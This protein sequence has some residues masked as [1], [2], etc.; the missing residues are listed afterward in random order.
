MN[1]APKTRSSR[2]WL[3][4]T[5]ALMVLAWA[6]LGFLV[7]PRLLRT[8]AIDTVRERLHREL[9]LG[10]IGFNPF[11]FELTVQDASLP[12][13][14]GGPAL[15]FQRLVL[16]AEPWRSLWHR[17][18][19]LA[20]LQVDGLTAAAVIRRDGTLNLADLA[21][22]A[23]PDDGE[24]RPLRLQI[25]RLAVTSG[26]LAFRELD[27]P[28]PFET[29]LQPI[30]FE[31]Q[32][33]STLDTQGNAYHFTAR[34]D[35]G[36][37]LDWSGKVFLQPFRSHGDFRIG[38]LRATT[39]ANY[40]GE[41]LPFTVTSGALD[42][43]G[44]Y[45][46]A[47]SDGPL[48]LT[49]SLDQLDIKSLGLRTRA[50]TQDTLVLDSLQVQGAQANLTR[51]EARVEHVVLTGG[52]INAWL[53]AA[54]RL[55]LQDLLGTEQLAKP[56]SAP[57]AVPASAAPWHYDVP[58]IRVT[59][60]VLN[61]EDQGLDPHPRLQLTDI[62]LG[63]QGYSSDDT[64]PVEV[65]L[66]LQ[67]NHSGQLQAAGQI[68]PRDLS[69]QG[70]L[71]LTDIDLTALQPY[72]QRDTDLTL[73]GG[74]LGA[75]LAL[76]RTATG[77]LTAQGDAQVS[78][79]RSIDNLLRQDFVKW[80]RLQARGI[81]YRSDP[82]RL[83]VRELL[84]RA[85]YARVV[86]GGDRILNLTHILNPPGKAKIQVQTEGQ[87]AVA[88]LGPPPDI[89]I[90]V[91]RIEKAAANFADFWIKPNF[92]VGLLD[93]DGTI[94][95]LSAKSGSRAQVDLH[96]MVDRYAPA[97]IRGEINPL[98]ASAYSDLSMTFRNMDMTTV[99]PYSG[100]FAGYQIRKGKLS[101]E[102]SYKIQD[103]KL[104]AGHHVVIDQLELGERV[105]SPDAT[106]LPVR[107]AVA[108]LK[109]RH[110][111][112]DVQL[113]VTGSLDD[114][115]F[116]LS[117]LVWKAI[118]NL[119]SKA[120]TAPFALL[121]GLFG[122]SD[123]Q[124]NQIAFAPGSSTPD[125]ASQARLETLR[126][127]LVER[128]GLE[129]EVPAA[130][131]PEQDRPALLR[132]QLAVRL[133]G[134]AAKAGADPLA[135][136]AAVFR[137]DAGPTAPLPTEGTVE[138]LETAVLARLVVSDAELAELGKARAAAVQD[139]LFSQGGLDPAR[140]FVTNGAPASADAQQLRID[141]TLK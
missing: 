55:N 141:L 128:P 61:A 108:L 72:L 48:Q 81:D 54:G 101:V 23:G 120:A 14:D 113:P 122:G 71:S 35:A 87:S 4:A 106:S 39:L 43:L 103:R 119:V 67:V 36:E 18:L 74:R 47:A 7:V 89:A 123:E 30:R 83:R 100:H 134:V 135:Q 111:V 50:A 44:H 90:G 57:A 52:T 105:E 41:R 99:T 27:H 88:A 96:G 136:L 95:G 82:Q 2:L 65:T 12:D 3:A 79:L 25:D 29:R 85:P 102:L 92:A 107:L 34:S 131:S 139:A 42:L 37:T 78:D 24:D 66:A 31:L 125:A 16:N 118:L 40:L 116:R 46:V 17:G 70:T 86:V 94:K 64:R 62:A 80:E 124:I 11:R 104:N 13:A 112:I 91:V 130:W 56:A 32:H 133:S 76:Q 53:S 59:G 68:L 73:L 1:V 19:S 5:V 9:Q 132:R 98:A 26:E 15:G 58:D 6:G 93:V 140:V 114:P 84:A 8:L 115:Q 109:D 69:G 110:G 97:I 33:F 121:G 137:E 22:L 10:Q 129:L 49:A 51:R 77:A 38:A 28:T 60:L 127:A 21:R 20:T 75:Q 63:L 117:P 138:A 45:D 126:K